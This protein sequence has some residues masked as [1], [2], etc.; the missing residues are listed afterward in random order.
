VQVMGGQIN[1]ESQLG[2]GSTFSF[3][4][5]LPLVAQDASP[6]PEAAAP[7]PAQRVLVIDDNPV[8]RELMAKM[9]R[10]LGWAVTLA[11]GGQAGLEL[12]VSQ[13]SDGA[14]P[15][16]CVYVDWQ[17]PG[18]D[19]WETLQRVRALHQTLTGPAP[20]LIMLSASGRDD[21]S[22]RTQA[23][24]EQLNAFLL[25]PVTTSMLFDA[26]LTLSTGK[27]AALRAPRSSQRQLAGMRVLVVE[28]NAI[29]QQVA[30]ELL[31]FEGAL[32]SIAADGRQG[33][34]AV[35]S[36]SQQFDAVLMDIQM[37]VMD[38]YA[39]TQ[40][41]RDKL[42]LRQLP[43][44]GLT[45]N[46]MAS[47]REACLLAGMNEHMGK[48]FDMAQLVALL[49]RLT[50]FQAGPGGPA[51]P[52]AAPV[53]APETPAPRGQAPEAPEMDLPAALERMGGLK[54][55][56]LRAAR[57]LQKTLA[58]FP[59]DLTAV[60]QADDWAAARGLLHT[61][62]G[63]AGTLGLT[64]LA[65]EL[66]VLESFSQSQ[67]TLA[68][69][70]ARLL[71]LVSGLQVAQQALAQAI[72]Q[73]SADLGQAS[74]APAPVVD[75]AACQAVVAQLIPLLQASDLSVLGVFADARSAL[76]ALPEAQFEQLEAALQDL[77]LEAALAVCRNIMA[78]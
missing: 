72:E 48:P 7:L 31:S 58:S 41:I 51:E 28:D 71:S 10:S 32:V 70:E 47:D 19:G 13:A 73:V 45:A 8:S 78:A 56:Y 9:M 24:Q 23:E 60:V 77:D 59:Q 38:G 5:R 74:A 53:P 26:A 50:G 16:D 44:I 63:N 12:I 27:Q 39:A 2:E 68:Q 42:G 34:N 25:K 57:E 18:M 11:Q 67:P 1:I 20:R 66:A 22:Q 37:P 64:R 35:A 36:A 4:L 49:L 21:L 61:L 69:G 75:S 40:M 55:L 17:M 15:F 65:G 6:A 33:V 14:F 29:N 3:T 46:A 62:K 30:E 76:T 43:I 52:Q 54:S